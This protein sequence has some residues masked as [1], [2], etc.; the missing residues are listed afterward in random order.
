MPPRSLR[1]LTAGAATAAL[2]LSPTAAQALTPPARQQ[3]AVHAAPAAPGPPPAPAAVRDGSSPATAA[4]SCWEIAQDHPEAPSGAYWLL[5]PSMDAPQQF[6]CDQDT[7]GGGWVLV[8]RGRESWDRYDQGRGDPGALTRRE[9]TPA[10]FATVQLPADD[11]DAL[12]DGAPVSGLED[13]LRLVRARNAAGTQWQE[14]RM[15]MARMDGF[16]WSLL[17]ARHV[18]AE[19]RFE[20]GLPSRNQRMDSGLGGGLLYDVVSTTINRT[21]GWTLG[22][23]YG[24]WV[25]GTTDAAS[26]LYSDVGGYARPYAELYVRPRL[27]A[28]DVTFPA[29]P[30]TGTAPVVQ[31]AVASNYASPMRWGVTDQIVASSAEGHTPVQAFAQVGAVMFVGGNFRT[32]ARGAAGERVPQAALAAFDAT[33][34]EFLPGFQPTF[35]GQVKSLARMPD[36]TLLVGG[37]FTTVNGQAHSGLVRLDPATGAVVPGFDVDVVNRLGGRAASVRSI[38]VQ[39][40]HVYLGGDFTHLRRGGREV[41]ARATGRLALDGTPDATWS[42]EFNATVHELAVDEADGRVY[43]AGY[44]TRSHATPVNKAT[45]IS[46]EAG[47]PVAVPEFLFS[48]SSTQ[49]YQQAVDVAG[50]RAFFGGSQHS[51]FTYDTPTMRRTTGTITHGNGGDL[52]AIAARDGIVYGGCHC[53]GFAYEDAYTWPE[54][55]TGWSAATKVQWFAAWD[56]ATGDLVREFTPYRL[57]SANAGAWAL[58]VADDGAVWAGGD[59]LGSRTAET[60][61]QWNGGFVRFPARDA[62]APAT[63]GGL[64]VEA[65]GTEAVLAWDAVPDAAGYEIL[66]DDRVVAAV[67]AT[68]ARVARGGADRF[69]VRA[70]DAAG[71]RSASTPARVPPAPAAPGRAGWTV[72]PAGSTWAYSYAAGAAPAEWAQAGPYAEGWPAGPAPLGYGQAGLA[73]VVGPS[74]G[75]RPVTAYFRTEVEIEDPAAFASLDL[76]YLADDGAVVRVNGVEVDRTRMSPGPVDHETRATAAVRDVHAAWSRVLVPASLLVA[77]TNVVAVET[78]LNYRSSATLAFDATATLSDEPAPAPAGPAPEPTPTPE[79]TLVPTPEPT[80]TAEPTPTP[81]PSSPSAPSGVLLTGGEEWRYHYAAAP[82]EAAWASSADLAGW[83]TAPA[84]LGWG[85]ADLATTWQVP[86]AERRTTAYFVRD[87]EVDPAR[88]G[89]DGVLRLRVRADDGVLVRVNGEEVGRRRLGAAGEAVAPTRYADAS[90]SASAAAADPL[91][92]DVPVTLLHPGANR[93]AVETHLNH[94]SAPSMTF[95]LTAELVP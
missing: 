6:Y 90:V 31:R 88:L 47:A 57:E 59:F 29:I 70:V 40:G 19:T 7:D 13:G 18:V 53:D 78:H 56:A 14:A 27:T 74:S 38:Q 10:D 48:G 64:R 1:R 79:P 17:G 83:E 43:A 60:R 36:S 25:R 76:S 42:P 49:D 52:Q 45:V 66:R 23:A 8:G 91:V 85:G 5:T 16:S 12:L 34:G 21:Q 15:R 77:G 69:V 95:G 61:R 73:T 86:A 46:P 94:R 11:V 84:P 54:P 68:G 55:G 37:E 80:P 82:V 51:F 44:F 2:L 35:D 28:R 3:P 93:I 89:A 63:P 62:V 92:V 33:S 4:V 50:P 71:N 39:G 81:E 22:F 9:R 32:V 75:T 65:E 26:F 20:G 24:S 41:Y 30:E 72:L 67:S 87:V 58:E